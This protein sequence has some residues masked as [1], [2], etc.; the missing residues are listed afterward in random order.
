MTREGMGDERPRRRSRHALT[1]VTSWAIIL[2]TLVGLTRFPQ[3]WLPVTAVCLALFLLRAIFVL[4]YSILGD[5]KCRSWERTDWSDSEETAG[6][7][8]LA[9]SEVRHVVLIPN[10]REPT[11]ILRRT[12]DALAVQHEAAE[13]LIVVLGMEEREQAALAKGRGLANEYAARFFETI[14]TVHPTGLPGEVPGKSSNQA[15]ELAVASRRV[16]ELGIDPDLVTITSCDADSVIHPR[17]FAAVSRLFADAEDRHSRFWQAPMQYLNNIW[18]VPAPVRFV[19]WF[20]QAWMRANLT[21]PFYASFPISTY[22]LSLRLA[23]D[24][25]GWDPGVIPEDW[26]MF[27]KCFFAR[28]EHVGLTPVFLPTSGDAP[29]G[30]TWVSGM[31]IAFQ[32]CVRHS[33]GAED[34]GYVLSEMRRRGFGWRAAARFAQA[35]SDHVVRAAG[36]FVVVSAYLLAASSRPSYKGIL[37]GTF[38]DVGPQASV[39]YPLFGIGAIVMIGTLAFEI[40]R[41]QMPRNLSRTRVLAEQ[42]LMWLCLPLLGLYLGMLPTM[43][44]QTMLMLGLPLTYKLTPKRI[45]SPQGLSRDER[46]WI[47]SA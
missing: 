27:L 35:Y 29:E 44:A 7:G 4:A 42:V 20:G 30:D 8:G 17:Y 32:Q 24:A 26:H 11:A 5:W 2:I 39:L 34:V 28:G 14:V 1:G 47:A 31:K 16:C 19:T 12:L 45:G 25:G 9:P 21:M 18:R 43:Q 36:W 46:K 6:R 3:S 40:S 23:L 37:N 33:W 13:R 10:F 41:G 22:T 15:W 38:L